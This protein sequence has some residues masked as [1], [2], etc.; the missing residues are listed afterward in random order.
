MDGSLVYS[1]SAVSKLHSLGRN[2][3][4]GEGCGRN[5]LV[6][7][8]ERT[9]FPFVPLNIIGSAT[10]LEETLKVASAGEWKWGR[11]D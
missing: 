11:F 6:I 1:E 5:N 2:K 9:K 8:H 4:A 7:L 10:S 3:Q